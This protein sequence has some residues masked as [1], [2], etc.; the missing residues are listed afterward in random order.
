[1][2]RSVQY[3]FQPI[4]IA[5]IAIRPL[6]VAVMA[7]TAGTARTAFAGSKDRSESGDR[8]EPADVREGDAKSAGPHGSLHRGAG[9]PA[10]TQRATRTGAHGR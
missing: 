3:R 4:A 5:S 6:S 10:R 9:L 7:R 1:M 2:S 8:G